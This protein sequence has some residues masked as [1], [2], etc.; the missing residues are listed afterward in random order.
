MFQKFH[1]II[2]SIFEYVAVAV[3]IPAR[4]RFKEFAGSR[5]SDP[6]TKTLNR[7]FNPFLNPINNTPLLELFRNCSKK[8]SEFLEP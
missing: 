3:R 2:D 8:G 4:N 5:N 6:L 1:Q 7:F